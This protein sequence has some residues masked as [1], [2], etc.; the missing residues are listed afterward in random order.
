M[1][2]KKNKTEIDINNPL[3]LERA[4]LSV[5]SER[6][7][8]SSLLFTVSA[9]LSFGAAI[10]SFI[11]LLTTFSSSTLLAVVGVAFAVIYLAL[12]LVINDY[13][14]RESDYLCKLKRRPLGY[15]LR[16][17]ISTRLVA[18]AASALG[19]FVIGAIASFVL[20][21]VKLASFA[22]L[23][24]GIFLTISAIVTVLAFLAA[25]FSRQYII[26]EIDFFDELETSFAKRTHII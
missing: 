9:V 4:K 21:G 1:L 19:I 11:L 10:A 8:F 15:L 16:A 6:L 18:T 12:G 25:E 14:K 2:F 24:S 23:V 7:K 17:K 5:F 3:E 26:E 20:F 22:L 13:T